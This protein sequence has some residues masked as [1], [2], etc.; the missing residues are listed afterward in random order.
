MV[1]QL[2]RHSRQMSCDDITRY[3]DVYLDNEFCDEDRAEFEA[4]LAQCSACTQRI[5]HQRQLRRT[6][7]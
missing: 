1:I 2:P 6:I 5:E 7:R 4:H 3:T